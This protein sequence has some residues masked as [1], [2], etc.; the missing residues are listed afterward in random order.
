MGSRMG[1]TRIA[2]PGKSIPLVIVVSL[3]ILWN[4]GVGKLT[5]NDHVRRKGLMLT[6][7]LVVRFED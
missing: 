5:G 1:R 6:L 3:L 7:G 2:C 4:G